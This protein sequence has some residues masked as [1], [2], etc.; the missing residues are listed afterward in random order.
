MPPGE[1]GGNISLEDLQ[2]AASDLV[3]VTDGLNKAVS[4]LRRETDKSSARQVTPLGTAKEIF[5]NDMRGPEDIDRSFGNGAVDPEAYPIYASADGLERMQKIG[6]ILRLRVSHLPDGT[7]LTVLKQ[8]KL[9]TPRWQEPVE[10][11]KKRRVLHEPDSAW[12]KSEAFAWL[13]TPKAGWS[14]TSPGLLE[15]STDKND[16]LQTDCLRDDVRE[17]LFA[18]REPSEAFKLALTQFEASRE[19]IE[20]L[21]KESWGQTAACLSVLTLNNR[22]RRK[23]SE[24]TFDT[25][26]D[27]DADRGVGDL[28]D[29]WE[30]SSFRT[31]DG[32]AV[33]SGFYRFGAEFDYGEPGHA[34][35]D[36]GVSSSCS[37]EDLEL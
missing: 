36:L 13:D 4:A 27:I 26:L 17:R 18:D 34:D 29:K 37:L 15:G 3:A 28:V 33:T 1:S 32:E 23:P 25:I 24:T 22:T 35:G 20:S 14:I 11:D 9:V 10:D 30:R 8:D 2:R 21:M 12:Y 5:G 31:S 19:V 7:P 6:R 16:L